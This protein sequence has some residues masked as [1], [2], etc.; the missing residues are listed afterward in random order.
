[1]YLKPPPGDGS[2]GSRKQ[3][4]ECCRGDG[5]DTETLQDFVQGQAAPG[6]TVY[7]DD[8]AEYRGLPNQRSVKHSVRDYVGRVQRDGRRC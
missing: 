3:R 1:M 2:E 7:T 4:G 8:H 6:A 5:T